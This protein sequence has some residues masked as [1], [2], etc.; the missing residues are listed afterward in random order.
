MDHPA[1]SDY[2]VRELILASTSPYR[3]QLLQRLQLPFRQ[4]KPEFIELPPGSSMDTSEL[5]LHNAAGKAESIL[6][7]YPEATVIASDQLAVCGDTVLGKPGDAERAITQPSILSGKSVTFLTSLCLFSRRER[8][9]DIIPFTV[10]FREL[11]HAEICSYIS[12]EKPYDC[13]GSFKS[14]AL[15]ITLFERMVGDDPTALIGLP[16]IRVSHVA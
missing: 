3:K 10:H 14:E 12:C 5:V 4:V 1:F 8:Q 15:G 16:L 9:Q 2:I 6:S 11:S 7:R 13:A